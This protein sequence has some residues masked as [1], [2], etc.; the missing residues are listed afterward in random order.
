MNKQVNEKFVKLVSENPDLP[1]KT[2]ISGECCGDDIWYVGEVE[3][4]KIAEIALYEPLYLDCARYYEKDDISDIEE[5]LYE[6]LSDEEEYE[7]IS[8]KELEVICKQKA[9]E[10]EWQKV[11]L[12]Y[13]GV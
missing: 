7:N 10:L 1:I 4:C 2:Y 3:G 9:E 6:R 5:D 12:L 8:D 11:I 13:V